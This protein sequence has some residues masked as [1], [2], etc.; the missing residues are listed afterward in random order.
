MYA[1]STT[2]SGA[3]SGGRT[4]ALCLADRHASVTPW[5]HRAPKTVGAAE[6]PSRELHPPLRLLR[7]RAHSIHHRDLAEGRGL[8]PRTRL[9]THFASNEAPHPAGYL[10]CWRRR[11]ESN[12]QGLRSSGFKPGPVANRVAPPWWP[13]PEFAAPAA[14][15]HEGCAPRAPPADPGLNAGTGGR[16]RSRTPDPKART[17]F[18]P[19]PARLSG[20][21]SGVAQDREHLVTGAGVEPAKARS[22]RR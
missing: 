8:E 7:R 20:S 6:L 21:P 5:P 12:P 17:G 15:L 16:R 22:R 3:A 1:N 14:Q 13:V 10:P 11:R 18:E 19:V 4:R 9:P 2:R